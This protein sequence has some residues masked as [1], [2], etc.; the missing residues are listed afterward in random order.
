KILSHFRKEYH[1]G[2][3]PFWCLGSFL[4]SILPLLLSAFG[5]N[6]AVHR[7]RHS[8]LVW[9][10]LLQ[11]LDMFA[12]LRRLL[13]DAA[14]DVFGSTASQQMRLA[15]KLLVFSRFHQVLLMFLTFG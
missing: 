5:C 6:A 1:H 3:H 13:L 12:V 9:L 8:V 7:M 2:R 14:H 11:G 15:R 4:R 10:M